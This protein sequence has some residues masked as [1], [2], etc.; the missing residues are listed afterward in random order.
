MT[1]A[2]FGRVLS[3]IGIV[4]AGNHCWGKWEVHWLSHAKRVNS[5]PLAAFM[6]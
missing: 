6:W 1:I 2:V 3:L 5:F 4:V